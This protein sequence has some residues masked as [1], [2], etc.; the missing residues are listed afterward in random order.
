MFAIRQYEFGAPERL[1]Y[2]PVPDPVPGARQVLIEVHAAGVHL[3]DTMLRAG[4]ARGPLPPPFWAAC[5]RAIST[6]LGAHAVG[7]A[8][9]PSIATS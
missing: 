2:E 3:I 7:G 1:V 6:V 9:P 8:G 5:H 4:G